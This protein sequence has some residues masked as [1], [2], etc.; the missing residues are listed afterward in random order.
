[1]EF[2]EILIC[3]VIVAHVVFATMQAFSWPFVAKRLLNIE[4]PDAIAKTSSV[5]KSFASYNFS[6]AIGLGL[7]FRISESV[8]H[9][10]QLTVMALIVFTAIVG[11]LGTRSKVILV[12]RLLPAVAAVLLLVMGL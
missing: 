3:V 10:V 2:S 6:I 1:M 4:D 12:G 9:D 5:G 7:S 11:F 8:A